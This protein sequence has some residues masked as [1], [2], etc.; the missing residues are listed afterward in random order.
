MSYFLAQVAPK[1]VAAAA[2]AVITF[3]GF[4]GVADL[5]RPADSHAG[6]ALATATAPIHVALATTTP[7]R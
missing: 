6:A 4:N 1:F 3:A 7:A 5:A 2:C